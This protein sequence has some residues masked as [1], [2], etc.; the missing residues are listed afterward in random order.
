MGYDREEIVQRIRTS[1]FPSHVANRIPQAA[2]AG[3]DVIRWRRPGTGIYLISYVIRGNYLIVTGDVGDAIYR[4]SEDLTLDFLAGC[5]IDYFAGKCTAS[6]H[7]RG[8]QGWDAD[9]ARQRIEEWVAD[10]FDDDEIERRRAS[11]EADGGALI[12]CQWR[13]SWIQWLDHHGDS[14]FG[15][16]WIEFGEIG[17]TT[18]IRCIG[19]LIGLQMA[20]AQ[21]RE[22]EKIEHV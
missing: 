12:E 9:L 13:D 17:R 4:F 2:E 22:Q 6:E 20:C 11:I 14:V 19:H 7:G 5:D 18:D 16:D 15:S 21:L 10:G 3:M 8:Y 1:W